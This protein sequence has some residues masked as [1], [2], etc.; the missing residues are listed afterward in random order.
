MWVLAIRMFC[1]SLCVLVSLDTSC[2]LQRRHRCYRRGALQFTI[3]TNWTN[4]KFIGME[5][6]PRRERERE[7][8]IILLSRVFTFGILLYS[9]RFTYRIICIS[10]V[11]T[12]NVHAC[13]F[14][15]YTSGYNRS[16][17]SCTHFSL[18]ANKTF[19]FCAIVRYLFV[20]YLISDDEL[21]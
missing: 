3:K 11:V 18:L 21:A 9:F 13:V 14:N 20:L 5:R 1:L 8:K 4:N 16:S 6:N 7:R 10:L 19:F 17:F 2:S 12:H 15:K